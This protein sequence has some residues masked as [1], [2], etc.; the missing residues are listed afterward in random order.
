MHNHSWF[1]SSDSFTWHPNAAEI[2]PSPVGDAWNASLHKGGPGTHVSV[3]IPHGKQLR[4]HKRA[5]DSTLTA[6]FQHPLLP[7]TVQDTRPANTRSAACLRPLPSRR[8][9]DGLHRRESSVSPAHTLRASADRGA[10]LKAAHFQSDSAHLKGW[11][12]NSGTWW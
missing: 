11:G 8:C 9:G 5:E 12:L 6:L 4:L 10:A 3:L 2:A 1:Q 7:H